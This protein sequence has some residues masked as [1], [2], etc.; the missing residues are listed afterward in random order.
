MIKWMVLLLLLMGCQSISSLENYMESS[1]PCAC[2]EILNIEPYGAT[3]AIVSYKCTD[4]KER[5][6]SMHWSND[7]SCNGVN[8]HIGDYIPGYGNKKIE[9][10]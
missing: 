7:F 3:R 9:G 6:N 4:G 8:Y 10:N 1:K 2:Q 5:E